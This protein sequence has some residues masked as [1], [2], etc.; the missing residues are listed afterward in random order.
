MRVMPP[1]LPGLC[2]FFRF[3]SAA[4]LGVLWGCG[5]LDTGPSVEL[6]LEEPVANLHFSRELPSPPALLARWGPPGEGLDPW[7]QQW[8]QSWELPPSEGATSRAEALEVLVPLVISEIPLS[9][10]NEAYRKV[11]EAL[12][13]AEEALGTSLRSVVERTPASD[14]VGLEGPMLMALRHQEAARE[15]RERGDAT[16]LLL[17]TL[18][19]ADALRATTAGPLA[20][21]FVAQAERELRRISGDDTYPDVTRDRAARLVAGAR[22][23]LATGDPGLALQRAWYAVGLLRASELLDGPAAPPPDVR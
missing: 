7:L 19:A 2:R 6:R 20:Q 13:A 3:L 14:D 17:H 12:R 10:L 23:A 22:E 8:E 9:T 15:A 11:E 1:R 5:D 18:H 16:R 4:L 21:L